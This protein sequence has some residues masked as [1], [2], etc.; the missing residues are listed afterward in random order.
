[1]FALIYNNGQ[2]TPLAQTDVDSSQQ[3]ANAAIAA[4]LPGVA[5]ATTFITGFEITGLGATAANNVV[6]TVTGILGGTK[7]YELPIPAGVLAGIT[8]LVVEFTRP[9]PASGQ[10]QAIVVN[11][12]A[13]GAGNAA[14]AVTAHGFQQTPAVAAPTVYVGGRQVTVGSG[15]NDAS[16]G[17]PI[18]PG[19]LVPFLLDNSVGELFAVASVAGVDVRVLDV[20]GGI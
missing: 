10:N 12:P 19:L 1:M 20:A 9:I 14:V 15:P 8:P 13:A 5:G 6:V 17:I 4:T 7:T 16:G 3:G 18:P 2:P 11:V